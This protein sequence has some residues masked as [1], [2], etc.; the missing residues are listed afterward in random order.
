MNVKY[1]YQNKFNRAI[2]AKKHKEDMDKNY[3]YEISSVLVKVKSF[4]MK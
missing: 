1:Y 3:G 2:I 4:L